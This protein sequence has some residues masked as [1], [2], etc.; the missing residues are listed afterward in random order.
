MEGFL[1]KWKEWDVLL[2]T[3]ST[4][5]KGAEHAKLG[6]YLDIVFN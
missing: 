1:S 2:L 6:A 3:Q 5:R 4:Q